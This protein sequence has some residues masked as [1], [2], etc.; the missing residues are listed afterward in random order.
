MNTEVKKIVDY[1]KTTHPNP[2]SLID[3]IIKD[4]IARDFSPSQIMAGLW[5]TRGISLGTSKDLVANHP[6]WGA[7]RDEWKKFHDELIESIEKEESKESENKSE[8]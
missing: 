8:S 3:E 2:T 5:Y 4:C 6:A 1:M 7:E